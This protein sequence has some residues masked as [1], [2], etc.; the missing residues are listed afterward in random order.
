MDW[1]AIYQPASWITPTIPG[2]GRQIETSPRLGIT[3]PELGMIFSHQKLGVDTPWYE[4]Q[5]GSKQPTIGFDMI[6]RTENKLRLF[7]L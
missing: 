6:E 1:E 5:V 3:Q 7:Y 2:K 4:Q